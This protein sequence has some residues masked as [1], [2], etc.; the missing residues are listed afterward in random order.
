VELQA[1]IESATA[2]YRAV[3]ALAVPVLLAAGHPASVDPARVAA[4][5]EVHQA[6]VVVA[7]VG[8]AGKKVAKGTNS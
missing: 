3:A 6:W 4:A 1:E 8:V 7:G 5:L 2:A